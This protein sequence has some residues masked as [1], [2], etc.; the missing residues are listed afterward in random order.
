[1]PIHVFPIDP[2]GSPSFVDDFGYVRPG[3][4]HAH[5]GIDI[6]ADAGSKILAVDDGQIRF[7]TDPLGGNVFYLTGSDGIVYYGA[8]LSGYEGAAPRS[9]SAGE[10]VGY[11]GMTGNAKGTSPHLHF[12]MHPGGGPAVDPFGD[13]QQLGPSF[14]KGGQQVIPSVTPFALAAKACLSA[15]GALHPQT[16]PNLGALAWPLAQAIGEGSFTSYFKGTNNVGAMHATAAFQQT[17]AGHAGYGM[18]AFTDGGPSGRYITRMIVVPSLAIGFS[19]FLRLVEA[20]VGGD[21][22]AVTDV[23]DYAARL[24]VHGYYTGTAPGP[25]TPVA[26]RAA[27]YAA[28][29]WTPADRANIAAYAVLVKTHE[30]TAQAAILAA[31]GAPGDPTAKT[32]GPPFAPLA[33]RLT[34]GP[35][36][37]PHTLAHARALLGANA[38]TPP[39]GG[40]ALADALAAPGGDGVWLFGQPPPPGPPPPQPSNPAP[41]VSLAPAVIAFG[42]VLVA[43][44][45]I[46]LGMR[47]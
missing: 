37:A 35:L 40:I 42:A 20:D 33:D 41:G 34:P 44:G 19:A 43:G 15:W 16:A 22:N 7:A 28:D 45:A 27:A 10:T 24:Y 38:D 32:S 30:A 12:E 46:A 31:P 8:H 14:A 39:P 11:V 47:S 5:Q 25:T 29:S 9:V 13:L 36:L 23:N 3:S 6:H 21:L 1:V 26:Q 2:A 18:V 4:T 17:H